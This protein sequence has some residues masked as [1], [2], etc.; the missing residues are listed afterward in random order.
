MD[1]RLLVEAVRSRDP[2]ALGAVYDAYAVRLYG[3]CWFRLRSQD[4]AQVALRDTFIVAEAHLD[5]LRAADR[6]GPWLFAI[7][8]LECGRRM[9]LY[10]RPP[11]LQVASHDQHDVDQ[12]VLAWRAV[13]GLPP[14][15]RE[16]LELN[17]RYGLGAADVAAVLG[18]SAKEVPEAIDQATAELSA[19][20]VAELLAHEG[21]YDCF[22]RSQLLRGF[23][24]ELGAELRGQLLVHARECGI[25]GAFRSHAVSAA[26]VFGLLPRVEPPPQLKLRVM[27]CFSDSG[28]VSYRLFAA[29]RVTEFTTAGFPRQT[30]RELPA[31]TSSEQAAE[32]HW[33]ATAVTA[34][35]ATLV[36]GLGLALTWLM[37]EHHGRAVTVATVLPSGTI[38]QSIPQSAPPVPAPPVPAPPVPGS[39]R[40]PG[41]GNTVTPSQPARP[42]LPPTPPGHVHQV[43][44]GA[45]PTRSASPPVTP[46]PSPSRTPSA[47]PTATPMSAPVSVQPQLSARSQP[48]G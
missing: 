10:G 1:D 19:G 6:F 32:R 40:P 43:D 28:L 11:D 39:A 15:S 12:R 27:S 17:S 37:S 29:T 34:L 23:T 13:Q 41:K 46:S 26:K 38:A 36:V 18:L 35:V 2:G 24:G 3:Y 7:A 42:V 45:S 44:P 47:S 21:P 14:L 20:L 16:L 48:G 30:R 31:G 8:R 22:E 5:R 4:A 25:C 9:P 33:R